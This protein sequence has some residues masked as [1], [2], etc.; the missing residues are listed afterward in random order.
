MVVLTN[1]Q[2]QYEQD[3][4]TFCPVLQY[5]VTASYQIEIHQAWPHLVTTLA[6]P[7]T[8]I[9]QNETRKSEASRGK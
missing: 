9:G 6:T 7:C 2:D 5:A 1:E 8:I 4:W 3:Q